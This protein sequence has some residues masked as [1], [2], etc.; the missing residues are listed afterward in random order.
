MKRGDRLEPDGT[1]TS[2]TR[3]EIDDEKELYFLSDRLRPQL[4][5]INT[6]GKTFHNQIV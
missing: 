2:K 4:S 6:P 3:Q 5:T 1:A